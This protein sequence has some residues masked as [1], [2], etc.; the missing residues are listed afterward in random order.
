MKI[1]GYEKFWN[2]LLQGGTA[3]FVTTLAIWG[4]STVATGIPAPTPTAITAAVG[5]LIG[6]FFSAIGAYMAT[7]SPIPE[8]TAIEENTES[9]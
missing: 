8:N 5:G 2:A 9:R 7:N 4:L 1:K 6:T 3:T